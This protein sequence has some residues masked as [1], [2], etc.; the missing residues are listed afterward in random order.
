MK[1]YEDPNQ[2]INRH[3]ERSA[4]KYTTGLLKAG[5]E[6]SKTLVRALAERSVQD[7]RESYRK[8]LYETHENN[9]N[10]ILAEHEQSVRKISRDGA[11][12]ALMTD[13]P[14]ILLF[15]GMSIYSF[16]QGGPVGLAMAA[17]FALGSLAFL[18]MLIV[19]LRKARS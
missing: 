10:I 3:L 7:A 18:A 1:E 8:H 6:P 2:F 4:K 14:V 19:A 13:P 17:M 15:G 16:L 12:I 5:L 11:R 9:V